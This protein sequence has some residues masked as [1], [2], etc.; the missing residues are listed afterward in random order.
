MSRPTWVANVMEL[1]S[2][3]EDGQSIGPCGVHFVRAPMAQLRAI[4]E[5]GTRDLTY[6]AWG[7]GLPLEFLLSNDTVRKLVFCFSSFDIFGLAPRFRRALE[8]DAIEVE[9]RS[10]LA[11][12]NGLRAGVEQLPFA[13]L[14]APVAS[15]LLEGFTTPVETLLTGSDSGIVATEALSVDAFL[16]HAHRADDEGNVEISGARLLDLPALFGAREV[17]VTV[18]ERVPAGTLGE[19]PKSFIVPRAF[20]TALAVAPDGAY[21]TSSLPY[22]PAD[23]RALRRLAAKPADEPITPGDLVP[24]PLDM[25][26]LRSIA[27]TDPTAI[28]EAIRER[29]PVTSASGDDGTFEI[30]ELMVSLIARTVDDDSICSVGSVSPLAT[31][32]Y[33][34]AKHLW[35]PRA[36]IM[37]FNGSY[38]DIGSRPMSIISSELLDYHSAVSHIGSDD[39]YHWY[40]Q[41][42][43]ITHEVVSAAQIDRRAATN[44]GWITTSEGRR[45]RLPGQGGMADV[46]DMH[47][48]FFLYLPRH[49]TRTMVEEVDFVT[50]KRAWH[51]ADRVERGYHPGRVL[52]LTNLGMFE[53]DSDLDELVLTQIHPGVSLDHL[54]G[55]TGFEVSV[56]A[57]LTES[58]PPTAEELQVIREDLDPLGV[59]R[60]EFVPSR[61]RTDLIDELLTAE[62]AALSASA[63]KHVPRFRRADAGPA[64]WQART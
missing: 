60:L 62:E 12:M 27:A 37:S 14:Q 51:G 38:L 19:N 47:R 20:V 54:R 3:V 5:R 36:T 31:I 35:A 46:A 39:S 55:Q 40:Y 9:E 2:H 34:L 21:P 50:A 29:S 18:E 25:D 58:E 8:N 41:R 63:D 42:G 23:Y 56:S 15:D 59:R 52:V 43:L 30:D 53:Y 45:I 24:D 4:V 11:F 7:G 49:S 48:D 10:A 22:Y 32:A 13:V 44:T 1:A 64:D 57:A 16:L 33:L 26:P 6:V 61:E 17:L 28:I